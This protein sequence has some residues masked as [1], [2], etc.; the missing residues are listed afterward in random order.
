MIAAVWGFLQHPTNEKLE[1]T[2]EERNTLFVRLLGTMV[3]LS[4]LFGLLI[5]SF[6][7]LFDLDF[8][9]HAVDEL[10][11]NYSLFTVLLLAVVLAP[12]LE[13]LLFRAPLTIFKNPAHF[14]YA[15]YV[16]ILLF[17]V[18]HISNYSTIEGQYWAIPILVSPQLSAGVFLGYI[19][20]KLGLFWSILLHAAHNL[21]LTAPLLVYLFL[22]I[23]L[24]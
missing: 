9:D 1:A 3:F 12:I 7:E 14:K 11:K 13:E 19:R 2:S 17:G 5:G 18:I 10:F 24:E 22:E 23:P 21:V 16:S 15:Y 20:I 6:S 4:I 8:G